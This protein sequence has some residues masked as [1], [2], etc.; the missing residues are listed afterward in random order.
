MICMY[1]TEVIIL[2]NLTVL[3]FNLTYLGGHH[4]PLTVGF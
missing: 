4:I 2:S 1:Y 3:L